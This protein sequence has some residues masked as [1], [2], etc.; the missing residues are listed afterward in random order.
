MKSG[1]D[2]TG[3]GGV[4]Y[5]QLLVSVPYTSLSN[6]AGMNPLA[7]LTGSDAAKKLPRLY[8]TQ[9]FITIFAGAPPLVPV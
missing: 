7:K 5:S 6:S 8:G 3:A 1:V 9:K 2:E 4:R